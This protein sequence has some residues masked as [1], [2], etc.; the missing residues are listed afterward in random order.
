MQS[1][2]VKYLPWPKPP[3]FVGG[4]D[5]VINDLYPEDS[6]AAAGCVAAEPLDNRA[7]RDDQITLDTPLSGPALCHVQQ[8][9]RL[10]LE[11]LSCTALSREWDERGL[12]SV[13]CPY[14][15]PSP[16]TRRV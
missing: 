10:H 7:Q 9:W 6:D 14:C 11:L 12:E 15:F 13:G 1:P 8:L 2:A 5:V 4:S 16:S 3:L